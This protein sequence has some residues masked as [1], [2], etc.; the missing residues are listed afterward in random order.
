[1]A[2]DT[3]GVADVVKDL[4]TDVLVAQAGGGTVQIGAP[5]NLA[6]TVS[7]YVTL[8]SQTLVLKNTGTTQ[9]QLRLL[10]V[11]AYRVAGNEETAETV[12][13]GLVDDIIATV[14]ADL[15]LGGVVMRAE[16]ASLG[17]DEPEYMA[18]AGREFRQYP[19][20]LTVW[21]QSSYTVNP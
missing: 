17:A 9:R 7:A 21:Q 2:Y 6:T 4:L 12:L 13:M 1:M 15:T 14:Y 16:L 5:L 10:I 3:A 18:I 8:G 11:L 19:L 20:V